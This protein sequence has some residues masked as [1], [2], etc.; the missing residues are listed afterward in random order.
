MAK[1]TGPLMSLDASGTV[2]KTTTF[3][4]WKGRNYVRLRV[5]PQN[6]QS[7]DQVDTR[8][9][10]G[11]LAKACRAV[12]TAFKDQT[13][14]VGSAFFQ[15]AVTAAPTGQSWIS[16]LQMS[17]H[18]LVSTDQTTY[19]GLS[20]TIRGY[21]DDAADTLGLFSYTGAGSVGNPGTTYTKG[22]QVYELAHFAVQYLNYTGFASGIDGASSG[23]LDAFVTYVQTTNP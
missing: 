21:Y 2:G 19:T 5:I 18:D 11:V 8:G 1:V 13:N 4:K 9:F 14:H 20:S 10:L 12:L 22:N 3:S 16:W 6:P 15:D 23:E 17:L 7:A